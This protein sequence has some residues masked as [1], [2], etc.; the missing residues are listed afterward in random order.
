[1]FMKKVIVLGLLMIFGIGSLALGGTPPQRDRD[2][3][4]VENRNGNSNRGN[5]RRKH[6]RRHRR[7]WRKHNM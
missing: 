3:N 1:M 4:R 7:H 2:R 6:R 5:W